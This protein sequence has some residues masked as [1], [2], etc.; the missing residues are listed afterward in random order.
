MEDKKHEFDD[1]DIDDLTDLDEL[2]DLD[3]DGIKDLDD[4]DATDNLEDIDN[5]DMDDAHKEKH[6]ERFDDANIEEF[7]TDKSFI[8][9]E[10][11]DDLENDKKEKD[12]DYEKEKEL[13]KE[14]LAE[15]TIAK[16]K[17]VVDDDEDDDD[18]NEKKGKKG[19]TIAAVIAVLVIIAVVVVLLLLK[20][21]DGKKYV[22]SFDTKGGNT[23]AEQKINENGT[24]AKP[25]DP[26]REGY[27]FDGWYLD[28]E[29]TEFDFSTKV[30]SDMKL[31]AHWVEK[32]DGNDID[33]ELGGISLTPNEL[34]L[35][36]DGTSSLTLSALP[37]G[38]DIPSVTWSSSNPNVATVD[39]QGNVVAVGE[40]S[41]I[42]TATTSDGKFS[43]T[44]TVTVDSGVVE[45]TG[46]T[47]SPTSATVV[48]GKTIKLTAKIQPANATNK[49]VTWTSDNS[50]V[51]KVSSSG[52]VTGVKPGKANITVKTA[53]GKTATVVVTVTSPILAESVSISGANTVV[54]GGTITLK[55]SI[56]PK[57]TTDQTVTWSVANGTGQASIDTK[58]GKLTARKAGTVTVTVRTANGKT[59]SKQ[60]TITAKPATPA[61]Y[62]LVLTPLMTASG[63]HQYN[64]EVL[65]DGKPFDDYKRIKYGESKWIDQANKHTDSEGIDCSNTTAVTA[66]IYLTDGTTSK[67]SVSCNPPE[68]VKEN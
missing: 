10:K 33:L 65:K 51:A 42:I 3:I 19:L 20:G 41:S 48:Q 16:R 64:F 18:E 43:A 22:V 13:S 66:I 62:R 28:G 46:V 30:K 63:I 44:C 26:T 12:D 14:V 6:E 32:D 9:E 24:I 59:A 38:A 56:L 53:N 47:I 68:E 35:S 21:C 49:V 39:D 58:T 55:A 57:D 29:T 27:E 67:I 25:A 2:D 54:E 52:V 36:P 8:D 11:N 4:V 40:G 15:D 50:S 23:I 34:T 31:E 5:L 45:E 7:D 60:I 61:S 1:L 37:F 17:V